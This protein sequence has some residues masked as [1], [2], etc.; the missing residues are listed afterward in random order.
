MND[1]TVGNMLKR[2]GIP[3]APERKKT[4]SWPEFIRIHMDML[5]ATDFLTSTVWRRLMLVVSCLLV[6]VP[7]GRHPQHCTAMVASLTTWI[8][9]WTADME[10]WTRSILKRVRLRL[11]GCGYSA[12]RPLLSACDFHDYPEDFP[13]SRGQ[14][15]R[16][17][18][19]NPRPIRNG[20]MRQRPGLGEVLIGE[21][22]EAA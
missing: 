13:R 15:I 17:S 11:L 8:S 16:L 5:G 22:R 20:P 4:I 7:G 2:H 18:V 1:Q 10:R 21:K 3:P 6:C 12:R 19:L 14:V 9:L